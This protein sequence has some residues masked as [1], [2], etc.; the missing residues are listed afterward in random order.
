MRLGEPWTLAHCI[1]R[2]Q[3]EGGQPRLDLAIGLHP[4]V[5]KMRCCDRGT[6][7]RH[8]RYLI[9]DYG[10]KEESV[11]FHMLDAACA[12]S[13]AT[14]TTLK[15]AELPEEGVKT[16]APVTLWAANIGQEGEEDSG[17]PQPAASSSSI[18]VT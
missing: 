11:M 13:R 8:A 12:C 14:N 2:S 18:F 10:D 17:A 9:F 6:R 7:P 3:P 1:H 5:A 4:L 15:G 16:S